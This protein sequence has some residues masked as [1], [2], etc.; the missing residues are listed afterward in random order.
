M[1][2]VH[3]VGGNIKLVDMLRNVFNLYAAMSH[4]KVWLCLLNKICLH[5][6]PQTVHPCLEIQLD[7]TSSGFSRVIAVI[8]DSFLLFIHYFLQDGMHHFQCKRKPVYLL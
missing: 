2:H 1:K 6:P 7:S 5:F 8:T 4:Y 3:N